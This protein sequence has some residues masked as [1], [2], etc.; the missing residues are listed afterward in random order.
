MTRN[1][2]YL[3]L[4]SQLEDAPLPPSLT[5]SVPGLRQGAHPEGSGRRGSHLPLHEGSH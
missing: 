4:L 2:E 5:D 3:A 1:E